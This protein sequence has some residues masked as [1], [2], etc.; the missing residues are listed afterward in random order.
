MSFLFGGGNN[1]STPTRMPTT[2]DAAARAAQT[3]QRRGILGRSGRSSTVM[4]QPGA[5]SAGAG[6]VSYANS[7]LG[8]AG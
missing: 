6:T 4:T 5:A 7:V 1:A 2:N 8:Q 3:R